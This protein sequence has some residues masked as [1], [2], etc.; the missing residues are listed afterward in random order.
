MNDFNNERIHFFT[1][2]YFSHFILERVCVL[3]CERDEW[4]Q[5][6]T[7]ILTQVLFLTIAALFSHLGW[8]CSLRATALNLQL[9]LTLTFLSPTELDSCRHLSIF[10]HSVHLLPLFFR[11]FTQVHLLID[12]S[13]E[14]Q[15]ITRRAKIKDLHAVSTTR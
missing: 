12:G 10:F 13:I 7:V 4:R 8:G 1:K 6:Q 11:L 14:G 2:I 9:V 5:G 3:L 15:Y